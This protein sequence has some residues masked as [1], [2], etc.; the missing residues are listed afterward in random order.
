M[1]APNLL[2]PRSVPE[3]V[4]GVLLSAREIGLA[5]VRENRLLEFG[6]TNLR[7]LQ[8]RET[9]EQRARRAIE[10]LLD[11]YTVTRIARAVP[12]RDLDPSGVVTAEFA[13]LEAEALRRNLQLHAYQAS[14]I[15]R[16]LVGSG[17]RATNRTVSEAIALRYQ[18]LSKY[19]PSAQPAAGSN[20][21]PELAAR[22]S[23]MPNNRERYWTRVFLAAGAAAYDLDLCGQGGGT[24]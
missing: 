14:D 15:R 12:D 5:I 9:K 22:R 2:N 17:R 18:A 13:W 10:Q 4:L 11:E 19:A 24:A 6:V 3:T 23:T 1:Q 16:A 21:V 8:S 7:K 20:L